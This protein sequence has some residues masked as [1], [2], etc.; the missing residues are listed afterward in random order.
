MAQV[1]EDSLR[2]LLIEVADLLS[3]ATANEPVRV[4]Y[5]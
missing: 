1:N 4:D 3:P 5:P 2:A